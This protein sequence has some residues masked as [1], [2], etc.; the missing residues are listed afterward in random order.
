M[1]R[2]FRLL[3]VCYRRF[4]SCSLPSS[5]CASSRVM[6]F[7]PCIGASVEPSTQRGSKSTQRETALSGSIIVWQMRL[8]FL[9]A[10]APCLRAQPAGPSVEPSTPS[11]HPMKPLVVY[12]RGVATVYR[13]VNTTLLPCNLVYI[14]VIKCASSTT[15]ACAGTGLCSTCPVPWHHCPRAHHP[16]PHIGGVVRRIGAHNSLSGVHGKKWLG[17]ELGIRQPV[18][19]TPSPTLLTLPILT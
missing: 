2:L 18:T 16:I 8:L 12:E 17:P 5:G 6:P 14:K 15:G 11:R 9:M 19:L 1:F 4:L 3:S 13:Q 10:F 7:A